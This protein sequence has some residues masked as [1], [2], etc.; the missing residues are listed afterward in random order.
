[1]SDCYNN[2]CTCAQWSLEADIYKFTADVS[3]KIFHY[4]AKNRHLNIA[5]RLEPL[6]DWYIVY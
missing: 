5:K 1:M 2:L 6:D 3:Y 4:L